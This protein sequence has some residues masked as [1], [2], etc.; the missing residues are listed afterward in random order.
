MQDADGFVSS[1]EICRHLGITRA[2]VWKQ[3]ESLRRQG[4]SI[5]GVSSVGYRISGLP[6]T[7]RVLQMEPGIQ[8]RRIASKII[9]KEE[10]GST[11]DDVWSLA[12]KGA[13]E[14]TVVIAE[15]QIAGKGRRGRQWASPAGVNLYLSVL[16]RP[17]LLPAEASLLTLVAA[18]QLCETLC[19]LF[20]SLRPQIKWPNDI[21]LNGQKTAGILAEIHAEQESIHFL[22]L[23]MGVNL[24]MT[25]EMFP[26]D[27]LYPAT[28]VAIALGRKVNRVSFARRLLEKLDMGY[29]ELLRQGSAPVRS[30]W[31]RHCAHTSG[32][33]EVK[34]PQ[35]ILTG[36]FKGIDEEGAMILE[37]DRSERKKIRAGDVMKVSGA[38]R[39]TR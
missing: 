23:G 39:G 4:F 7:L 34:T 31:I 28:S 32:R 37:T 10:T 26:S 24:N 27:I 33:L 5:E 15:S 2:A 18:V 8:T 30:S 36:L 16:L 3:V 12:G 1:Q 13:Q 21:L 38:S 17:P 29:D 19:E 22:V 6:D 9:V 35:G 25:K 20:S 14:G 11:N